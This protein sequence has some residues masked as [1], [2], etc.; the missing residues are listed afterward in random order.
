MRRSLGEAG[1][2]AAWTIGHGLSL[3]EALAESGALLI[4]LT[5]PGITT[6]DPGAA[7]A[8]RESSA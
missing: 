7:C 2:E 6:I 5:K 8:E 1:F 3:D 4:E